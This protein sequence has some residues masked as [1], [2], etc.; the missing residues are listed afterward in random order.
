MLAYFKFK[1]SKLKYRTKTHTMS[2]KSLD[3][4]LSAE[5]YE[6]NDDSVGTSNVDRKIS[7]IKMPP[8][9]DVQS[10][11][12]YDVRTCPC[13]LKLQ[14][15]TTV[16]GKPTTIPPSSTKTSTKALSPRKAKKPRS[17][18]SKITDTP[19]RNNNLI[20]SSISTPHPPS[21]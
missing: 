15:E 11:S 8:D 1:I 16:G 19:D 20:P 3:L 7:N 2:T 9:N 17:I 21:K 12:K 18:P 5:A 14:N 13:D 4:N 6:S 10:G